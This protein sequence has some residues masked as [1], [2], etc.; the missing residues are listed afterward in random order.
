LPYVT[1]AE[2]KAELQSSVVASSELD[3]LYDAVADT[4][5]TAVDRWCFRSFAVPTEATARTYR[6]TRDLA[7]VDELDDIAS[8]SGLVVK[9]DTAGD[10]TYATTLA[11]TDYVA[12]LDNLTGMVTVI[13]SAGLFPYSTVRP[14]SIQVTARY[15]WPATPDPVKRAAMI[16]A[17]RLVNRRSSPTGVMGFGEFGGIR[18]S[19]IDP[20]VR[21]LL[22]PY[23]LR[24][25]LLR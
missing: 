21:T 3:D 14:R 1:G 25:R 10:G 24:G 23:R 11:A 4:V 19:T 8:T 22:A 15:G 2:I 5:T 16:W 20:D 17:L 7:E 12:E 9:T 13:R 6:P 18:L